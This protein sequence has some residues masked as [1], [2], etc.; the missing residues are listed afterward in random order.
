MQ[1]E[2]V[3]QQETLSK[4][5]P[6]IRAASIEDI[7]AGK[8]DDHIR[9]AIEYAITINY[10]H[11]FRALAFALYAGRQRPSMTI[12]LQLLTLFM[13]GL[14]CGV[15][16]CKISFQ[17]ILQNAWKDIKEKYTRPE[18]MQSEPT[19][20]TFGRYT[21]PDQNSDNPEAYCTVNFGG[22]HGFIQEF[23]AG[24]NKGYALD[25]IANKFPG[26][27]I[28][29]TPIRS[30]YQYRAYNYALRAATLC[31]DIP[32]VITAKISQKYLVK[33]PNSS[34]EIGVPAEHYDKL[35]D[36]QMTKLSFLACAAKTTE[37][38]PYGEAM[39][40]RSAHVSDAYPT[41]P[42]ILEDFQKIEEDMEQRTNQQ[43]NFK[44]C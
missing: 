7:R 30:G 26:Y 31:C 43:P 19:P 28:Y 6:E 15:H 4:L 21:D 9:Q 1:E 34:Y 16:I 42:C 24:K 41:Q 44:A 2:Y 33:T 11:N 22:G 27:G 13:V 36:V 10:A 5:I 38:N 14:N 12:N 25:C 39:F 40:I 8:F 3:L 17:F 23:L 32:A 35:F 20:V 37:Q 18:V 29:V